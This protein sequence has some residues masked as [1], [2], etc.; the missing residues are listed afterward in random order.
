MTVP[1]TIEQRVAISLELSEF[2]AGCIFVHAQNGDQARD[3]HR[4]LA[5]I[6]DKLRELDAACKAAAVR[7]GLA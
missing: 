5:E 6:T 1:T 2:G 7:L 3:A 4:L